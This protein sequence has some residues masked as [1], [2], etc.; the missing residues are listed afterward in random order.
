VKS[1]IA[2][3]DFGVDKVEIN[4]SFDLSQKVVSMNSLVEVDPMIKEYRLKPRL[5]THHGKTP[6]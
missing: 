6:L 2:V 1:R 3:F 4:L 5:I